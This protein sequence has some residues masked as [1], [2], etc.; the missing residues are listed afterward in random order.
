MIILYDF[1]LSV[2]SR[3][4]IHS[5]K[6]QKKSLLG[7]LSAE[8]H[9]SWPTDALRSKWKWQHALSAVLKW[10]LMNAYDFLLRSSVNNHVSF[11]YRVE[12]K[13]HTRPPEM[14]HEREGERA[15]N[16]TVVRVLIREWITFVL[17][18]FK[19][20]CGNIFLEALDE[21]ILL[22]SLHLLFHSPRF[23]LAIAGLKSLYAMIAFSSRA[24]AYQR[25]LRK[26]NKTDIK[27]TR[28]SI[29]FPACDIMYRLF[30]FFLAFPLSLSIQTTLL[31]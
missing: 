2:A 31:S 1:F 24:M 30:L 5:G 29:F 28:V 21:H 25:Q 14:Q 16:A 10:I 19:I 8:Q 7:I 18:R 20:A 26:E 27:H 3:I 23:L 6:R 11:A 15:G 12:E 9:I 22:C 17:I 13:T 4:F